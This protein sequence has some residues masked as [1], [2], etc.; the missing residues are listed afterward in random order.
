MRQGR[1]GRPPLQLQRAHRRRRPR[2]KVG[3]G[4][5][6][7]NEVSEAIRKASDAAKQIHGQ[8]RRPREHHSA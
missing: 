5:G 4:F 8:G 2:G 1:E 3:F 6:K 7:A